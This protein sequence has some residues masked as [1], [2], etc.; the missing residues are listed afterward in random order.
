MS[1]KKCYARIKTYK[2]LNISADL[3]W[4]APNFEN[5]AHFSEV[6]KMCPRSAML[7]SK[8]TKTWISQQ[9][10]N[11]FVPNFEN[12]TQFLKPVKMSPRSAM[13]GSKLTKTWISQQILNWSAPNFQN[14][15]HFS[16]AVKMSPKKC[17]A[18]I[19]TYENLN[20]S[21]DSQ[22]ICTKLSEQG[23]C[24][25]GCQNESKK[26]YAMIKTEQKVNFSSGL[27]MKYQWNIPC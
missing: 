9:I 26:S 5:R 8:L 24:F 23:L 2:N 21:A 15:A 11:Q 3:N 13:L 6:V 27:S 17:Y 10:L 25:W 16:E 14:R 4:S 7:G 19:K 18:R 22:L 20:I 1:P 12:R